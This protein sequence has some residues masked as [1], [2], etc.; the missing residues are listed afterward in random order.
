MP[1][2]AE[3]GA[4]FK[5]QGRL[6]IGDVLECPEC[7]T[8]LEVVDIKPLTLETVRAG[9]DDADLLDDVADHEAPE[10]DKGWLQ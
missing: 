7:A 6:I 10:D 8:E 9:D 2:C 1:E 5:A 4:E 3:C